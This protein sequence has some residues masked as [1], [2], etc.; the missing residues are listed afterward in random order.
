MDNSVAYESQ[1]EDFTTIE[2]QKPS[3]RQVLLDLYQRQINE[4]APQP[5]FD[6][7][8]PDYLKRAAKYNAIARGLSQLANTTSLALGG[9]VN[10]TEPDQ[11]TPAY[12]QG[13][14]KYLDD[15]RDKTDKYDL[16]NYGNKLKLTEMMY[17]DA[18]RQE[19]I[20]RDNERYNDSLDY[21]LKQDKEKSEQWNKDYQEQQRVN[22]AR[23]ANYNEK[24][25]GRGSEKEPKLVTIMTSDGQLHEYPPYHAEMLRNEA[26]KKGTIE[27]LQ[28]SAPHLFE[29]VVVGKDKYGDPVYGLG[30]SK[31]VTDRDII[32]EYLELKMQQGSTAQPQ[33]NQYE[34]PANRP[35]YPG[36]PLKVGE[37]LPTNQPASAIQL[38]KQGNVDAAYDVLRQ[39]GYSDEA[40]KSFLDKVTG[41]AAQPTNTNYASKFRPAKKE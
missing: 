32:R 20:D 6:T 7:T 37:S 12:I 28:K 30:I 23:I 9:N 39:S 38:I 13:Y 26:L 14:L 22:N 24:P 3:G 25:V 41:Q 16:M 27:Q 18:L 5:K 8:N 19:G 1:L 40:I 34:N 29:Q 17:N 31:T 11:K 10:P 35:A 21:K 36:A 2:P 4:Q 15:Y 33:S